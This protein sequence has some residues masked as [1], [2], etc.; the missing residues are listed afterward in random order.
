MNFRN[1]MDGKIV[2]YSLKIWHAKK[3]KKIFPNESTK[4]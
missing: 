4:W 1:K 2:F 3:E